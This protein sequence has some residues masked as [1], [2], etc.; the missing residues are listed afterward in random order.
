[1]AHETR[2]SVIAA[3]AGS[4]IF[5]SGCLDEWNLF[6]DPSDRERQQLS[7]LA[8]T[9]RIGKD[10]F[11]GSVFE[12]DLPVEVE[13]EFE[14]VAGDRTDV[15]ILEHEEFLNYR[16]DRQFEHM[17]GASKLNS[18]HGSVSARLSEGRY[19]LIVDNTDRGEASPS[20]DGDGSITISVEFVS[21]VV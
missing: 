5:L 21:Y 12:F 2:R 20:E 19:E 4:S 1:M 10:Y 15:M 9:E 13:Y 18:S 6:V 8:F 16:A 7:E 14:V 17:K 11:Y 3:G